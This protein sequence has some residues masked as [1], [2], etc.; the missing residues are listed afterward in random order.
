MKTVKFQPKYQVNDVHS[1]ADTVADS[2]PIIFQIIEH[3][4]IQPM[5]EQIRQL[6]ATWNDTD[7]AIQLLIWQEPRY[8]VHVNIYYRYEDSD[9]LAKTSII[10]IKIYDRLS[11]DIEAEY[12]FPISTLHSIA[13]ISKV[14]KQLQRHKSDIFTKIESHHRAPLVGRSG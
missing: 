5:V 13:S 14:N 10:H 8:H 7:N 11:H 4:L 3:E 9:E 1:Y 2:S 6:N 12:K